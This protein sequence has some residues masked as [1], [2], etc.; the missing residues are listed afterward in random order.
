MR[1]ITTLG[2]STGLAVVA[3]GP[4]ATVSLNDAYCANRTGDDWC[5]EQ[6]PDGSRPY[7]VWGTWETCGRSPA[8]DGCVEQRPE[9]DECYSPCGGELQA[10]DDATCLEVEASSS[11]SSTGTMGSE[12]GSESSESGTTGTMPCM[13]NEDC[14]DAAAPFCEPDGGECVRCDG[15][16]DGDAACAELDAGAPLC[17]AGACVACTPEN[18]VVC[19]EQQLLCD[20]E[21][22]ACAPCTEHGQCGSGACELAVGRCFPEDFVVTVD[23]DGG[24]DYP[25][26]TAAVAAVDDGGHGVIVVHELDGGTPYTAAMG[27]TIAGGKTIALLAAPGELPIIQGTGMNPGLRVEGAGTILYMDGV[28]VSGAGMQGVVADAAFAWLDRSRIV[29]NAGGGIVAQNGAELTVR[30]CFVGSLGDVV[31]VEIT[32]SSASVL[33]STVSAS[34]FGMTPALSCTSPIAVEVRNSIIVSQ[35]GTPPDEVSCPGIGIIRS[36]TEAKVGSF[37]IG[38]FADYNGDDFTLTTM[39]MPPGSEVFAGIAQWNEGDPLTDI[40]GDPRP[41]TAGAADFA[42]ADVP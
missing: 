15:L 4:V 12:T 40:D 19:D 10:I 23:G 9:T 3:C 28:Q 8:R 11:G 24:A 34:T 32:E 14:P 27:L 29:G 20:G 36:A 13:G 30:N 25:S 21:T 16:G 31:G 26:V 18:P 39:G 38:W 42:G 7:C 41:T 6:Y 35:G 17:V 1:T 37:N 2:L 22:N 5:A 33:Y